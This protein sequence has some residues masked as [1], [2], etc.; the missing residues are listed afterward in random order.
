MKLREVFLN[1]KNTDL[2]VFTAKNI[3][4][5]AFGWMGRKIVPE[6][7]LLIEK[8]NSIH[9]FFMRFNIDAV[10]ITKNGEI[11]KTVENI[12]PWRAIFPVKN[13]KSVLELPAGKIKELS[14]KTG[15]KI[16]IN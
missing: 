4:D 2:K 8:C 1:G 7:A 6:N 11:I 13:T 10:F 12:L 5:K 16:G 3:L 9:T 14:I 15:D